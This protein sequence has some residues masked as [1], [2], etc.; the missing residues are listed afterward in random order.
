MNPLL[1]VTT[2]TGGGDEQ[3]EVSQIDTNKDDEVVVSDIPP[4][5]MAPP[6][7]DMRDSK[8]PALAKR[9]EVT[10]SGE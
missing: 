5:E 9:I 6:G 1:S 10:P 8:T 4:I 2:D 3:M 7:S